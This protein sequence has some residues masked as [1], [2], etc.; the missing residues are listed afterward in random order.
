MTPKQKRHQEHLRSPYWATVRRAV[1]ERDHGR[2]IQCGATAVDGPLHV[3]HL[4]YNFWLR[5]LDGLHT[6]ILLCEC[7]HAIRHGKIPTQRVLS[8]YDLLM[9]VEIFLKD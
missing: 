9:H 5:E 6:V 4:S 3:H 7:C 2:C 8:D 1:E